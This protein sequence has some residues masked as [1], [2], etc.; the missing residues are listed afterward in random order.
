MALNER[1]IITWTVAYRQQTVMG[2]VRID[3]G[4]KGTIHEFEGNLSCQTQ[5][6]KYNLYRGFLPT[7]SVGSWKSF[8]IVFRTIAVWR[9]QIFPDNRT[10]RR[11]SERSASAVDWGDFILAHNLTANGW[12]ARVNYRFALYIHRNA[13][14]SFAGCGIMHGLH[15]NAWEYLLRRGDKNSVL[16]YNSRFHTSRQVHESPFSLANLPQSA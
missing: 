5:Y 14:I 13:L 2:I 7:A 9:M 10:A 12:T 15:S 1:K 8:G 3:G 16:K 4:T 11:C 6:Y